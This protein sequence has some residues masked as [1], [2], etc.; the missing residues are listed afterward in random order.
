MDLKD[1]V[2]AQ[3]S[4]QE[5]K[6]RA[7]SKA[8]QAALLPLSELGRGGRQGLDLEPIA[9]QESTPPQPSDR[10]RAPVR[11]KPSTGR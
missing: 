8:L 5:G 2:Q 1:K 10:A 7:G 6:L 11:T 3:A 9:S 4:L